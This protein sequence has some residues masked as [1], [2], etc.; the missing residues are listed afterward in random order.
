MPDMLRVDPHRLTAAREAYDKALDELEPQLDHLLNAGFIRTPWLGD[1]VS[2][3]VVA[4]Y[5][6]MVMKSDLGTYQAMRR[7]GIE[8]KA[9][10]DQFAQMEQAYL[11]A[12]AANARLPRRVE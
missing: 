10:R 5:N 6:S 7:Y 12:E 8:L 4:R 9:I 11:A 2:N 3:E 1:N